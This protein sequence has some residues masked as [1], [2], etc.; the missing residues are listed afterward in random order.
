MFENG[1]LKVKIYLQHVKFRFMSLQFDCSLHDP[2]IF[3]LKLNVSLFQYNPQFNLQVPSDKHSSLF[4]TVAD[5]NDAKL[6][7]EDKPVDDEPGENEPGEN[8]PVDDKPVPVDATKFPVDATTVSN[9][10]K[11]VDDKPFLAD[12]SAVYD[13]LVDD[14]PLDDETVDD[15]TLNDEPFP[16]DTNVLVDDKPGYATTIPEDDTIFPVGATTL[17]ILN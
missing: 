4:A 1:V 12:A 11:T 3:P 2:F 15:E 5:I 14:T 17:I 8:V 13:E 7:L 9:V 6:L 16:A 10:G